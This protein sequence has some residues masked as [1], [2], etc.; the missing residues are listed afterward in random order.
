MK[1]DIEDIKRSLMTIFKDQVPILKITAETDKALELS[2]TK[3]AMQGT[4][5]VEGYYF[6]TILEKSKDVQLHFF[7]IYT[8][9]TFFDGISSDL[10]RCLKGKN[11][12]K[13]A[14]LSDEMEKEIREMVEKG[15][16]VYK[17]NDL[18]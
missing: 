18:I 3:E 16:E 12:F 17:D 7:P 8:H 6:G 4:K 10:R 13:I 5:K 11:C 2:G 14:Q 1:T 9:P 15:V